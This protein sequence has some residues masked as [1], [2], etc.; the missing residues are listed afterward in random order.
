MNC[1]SAAVVH[2]IEVWWLLTDPAVCPEL[3]IEDAVLSNMIGEI[4]ENTA[5]MQCF[6][7]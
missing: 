3:K 2:E 7:V 5:Y 4:A 6:L 1:W